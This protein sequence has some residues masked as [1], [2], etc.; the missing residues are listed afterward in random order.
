MEQRSETNVSKIK[1]FYDSLLKSGDLEDIYPQ[2]LGDWTQDEKGFIKYY[3][4]T[5]ELENE[6]ETDS[7]RSLEPTHLR[8]FKDE[9]G[10]D[11]D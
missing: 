6:I 11:E 10:I 2:S 7:L 4:E 3:F 8:N 1:S 5:I 9:L